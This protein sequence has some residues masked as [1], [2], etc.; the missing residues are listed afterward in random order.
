MFE[1]SF[2]PTKQF[3]KTKSSQCS[4]KILSRVT[5]HSDD[6][7]GFSQNNVLPLTQRFSTPHPPKITTFVL[8]NIY[9]NGVQY[10]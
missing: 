6:L 8:R 3:L 9:L 2:R 4:F 1:F 10:S 5:C 7:S